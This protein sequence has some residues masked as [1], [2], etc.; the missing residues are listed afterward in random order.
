M[1]MVVGVDLIEVR[2][3]S[4]YIEIYMHRAMNGLPRGEIMRRHEASLGRHLGFVETQGF[5]SIMLSGDGVEFNSDVCV[6][7]YLV[8]L[9]VFKLDVCKCS[10]SKLTTW[11]HWFVDS[12]ADS[13]Y[14]CNGLGH[15]STIR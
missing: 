11:L 2:V 15:V 5:V 7:K 6:L 3:E 8:R 9:N 14:P 1:L 12:R 10:V 4:I 13:R